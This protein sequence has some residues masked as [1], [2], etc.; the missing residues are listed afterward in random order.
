MGGFKDELRIENENIN[1]NLKIEK[2]TVITPC[3]RCGGTAY[4]SPGD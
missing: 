2:Q 3:P 4:L 1:K